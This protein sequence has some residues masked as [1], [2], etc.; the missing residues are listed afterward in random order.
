MPDYGLRKNS[1]GYNDPT[2]HDAMT[3]V[4][5]EE[6]EQL[7]RVNMV[8]SVIKSVVELAGFEL[9]ARIVLRDRKTGREYR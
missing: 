1:E 4:L 6:R 8:I 2:A 5:S 9:T 3:K 7:R